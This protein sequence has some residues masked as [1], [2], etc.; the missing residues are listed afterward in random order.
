MFESYD[1]GQMQAL[2]PNASVWPNI[3]VQ[4]LKSER[5]TTFTFLSQIWPTSQI[6][7][8][9]SEGGWGESVMVKTK[10]MIATT[11]IMASNHDDC[12]CD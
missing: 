4:M 3:I 2:E 9:K 8:E 7:G 11:I 10:T 1:L 12:E 5:S 6:C